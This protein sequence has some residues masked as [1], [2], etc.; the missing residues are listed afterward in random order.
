MNMENKNTEQRALKMAERLKS[1]GYH[2]ISVL[3]TSKSNKWI[4][5]FE[6]QEYNSDKQGIINLRLAELDED[7]MIALK[8]KVDKDGTYFYLQDITM[9]EKYNTKGFGTLLM[10]H[11]INIVVA[12]S[13]IK[14]IEGHL[15][16]E[17]DD[18]LNRQI[19][20]FEKKYG[21][22]VNGIHIVK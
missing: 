20:F 1:K 11:F 18:H 21:F 14:K 3:Q 9:P 7:P 10:D 22:T 17:N 6:S 5:L 16:S 19:Q 13:S 12:K 15:Y 8:Y 4:V 2:I